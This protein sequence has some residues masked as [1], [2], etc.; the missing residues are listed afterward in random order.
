[1]GRKKSYTPLN[2][3]MN[4]RF[5]G[6]LSRNSSGAI[7][8]IYAPTWLAWEGRMPLSLSLPLTSKKYH[9]ERVTSVFD[10][11]LPDSQNIRQRLAER[12]GS[13]GL[14]SYSMLSKIGRDCIGALQ[15][16]PQ[17]EVFS[18]SNEIQGKVLSEGDIADI[19]RN[20]KTKPLGIERDEDFRI[21]VAGAQEKTALLFYKGRWLKPLH[22]T[23][24]THILKPQIG[25]LPNGID[26]SNSVENEYY[27]LKLLE[28]F[29]LP[30]NKASIEEFGGIKTLVVE[31]FDR[32]W[33]KDGRLLR[34]PQEDFCQALSIPP[35]LK[36]ESDGGPGMSSIL[37]FLKGSDNPF[38]DQSTFLKSQIIF[39]L[40]GATDGHGKN[41]S[42]F[43]TPGGHFSLTPIYDVLTAQPSLECGQ[44]QNKQMKM[45]MCVGNNRHY[46]ISEI[47]ARHFEES[48][49]KGG[50]PVA[51]FKSILNGVAERYKQ[52]LQYVEQSLP[53]DFPED[54]HASVKKSMDAKVSTLI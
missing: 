45:A 25:R 39:W 40:I 44:I 27:C 11:L 53:I 8:F 13:E 50:V 4:N 10:N 19:L 7:S 24:T 33:A 3:Y 14:D 52:A 49:L 17:G 9:G 6:V 22:T 16:I 34:L 46:K 5:I 41:F 1:M 31:R 15:L 20:L 2:V 28:G 51:R 35:T 12:V 26:L 32:K 47:S 48:A 23:P 21:S 38:V 42:I 54:I 30:V 18:A 43:I 36:Y 29:G 37:E